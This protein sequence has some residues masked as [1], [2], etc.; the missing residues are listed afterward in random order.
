MHARVRTGIGYLPGA[1]VP[2]PPFFTT[3][4]STNATSCRTLPVDARAH[5]VGSLPISE[6][7]P[8]LQQRD[9]RQ[10]CGRLSRLTFCRKQIGK[11]SITEEHAELIIHVHDQIAV[12]KNRAC[13]PGSLLGNAI[14]D[15]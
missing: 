4:H 14:A 2:T 11:V 12:R 9:E 3:S 13:N 10:S 7:F 15:L 1:V 5:G 6:A 8:E